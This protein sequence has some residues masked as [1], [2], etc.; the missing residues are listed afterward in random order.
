MKPVFFDTPTEF[1]N[2][3]EKNH[4]SATEIWV[5]FWKKSSGKSGLNY[6]QALDEALCYG[7]IDGLAHKY[8]EMSYMQ[9]FSPRKSKSLWSKINTQNVERLIKEGKMT[10]AG[11]DVV[12]AAKI[13]GRWDKAYEASSNAKVPEDFIKELKKNQK[14]Y[15]FFKTLNK[16]NCYHIIFQLH[17]TRKIETRKNKIEKFIQ[18]LEKG[19][20]F[21]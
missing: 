11:L 18:K 4:D 17:N 8:D 6:Q 3:L 15:A 14:A 2:W 21:Y 9:R 10:K 1:R 5:G 12:E 20:R 19:E 13:D 7:W 16:A